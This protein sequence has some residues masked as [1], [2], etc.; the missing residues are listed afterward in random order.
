MEDINMSWYASLSS[1][2]K[3][4]ALSWA[5]FGGTSSKPGLIHTERRMTCSTPLTA[6]T[7]C[8]ATSTVFTSSVGNTKIFQVQNKI[9]TEAGS[10]FVS[11]AHTGAVASCSVPSS[12]TVPAHSTSNLTLT[13]GASAKQGSARLLVSPRSFARPSALRTIRSRRRRLRRTLCFARDASEL[14]EPLF[15]PQR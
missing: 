6:I 7:P 11:C 15:S 1:L 3:A 13:Y 4:V 10:Y 14:T 5:A 2:A 8:T 9:N 12:M